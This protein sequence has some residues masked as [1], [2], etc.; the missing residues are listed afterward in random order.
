MKLVVK[1][2]KM[3]PS[4]MSTTGPP[5]WLLSFKNPPKVFK[6]TKNFEILL[7][8]YEASLLVSKMEDM[9]EEIRM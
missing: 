6:I 1:V 5:N 8:R 4:K 9:Q 2:L 3:F 7:L